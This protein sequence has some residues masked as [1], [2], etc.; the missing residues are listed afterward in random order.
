MM[1]RQFQLHGLSSRAS[2]SGSQPVLTL[3]SLVVLDALDLG[4]TYYNTTCTSSSGHRM[5]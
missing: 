1:S 4:I 2:L 3:S 5:P